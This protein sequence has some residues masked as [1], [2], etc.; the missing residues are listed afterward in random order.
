[1]TNVTRR[2]VLTTAA[3]GAAW[4]LASP[5]AQAEDVSGH[6]GYPFQLGVASGEPTHDGFVIWTRLA[7]DPLASDGLGGLGDKTTPVQW[8]VATDKKFAK[9]VAQGTAT[10]NHNVGHSVHVEVAKLPPNQ[11][12]Y[13]RF[14]ALGAES[15]VG[16]ARTAPAAGSFDSARIAVA[17]CAQWEHGWFS[18]YRDIA[19]KNPDLV[20]HLGDYIYEHGPLMYPV[21]SGRV[22]S[23]VGGETFSLA[24]YRRR[25]ALYRTDR[26][27]QQAHQ[28]APWVTVFDDHEVD[29]DWAGDHHEFWG[30]TQAFIRRKAAAFQAFYENMPLRVSQKPRGPHL[31]LHRRILW[32]GLFSLNM[33]DTRQYRDVQVCRWTGPCD[34]AREPQRAMLGSAQERWLKRGYKAHPTTWQIFGNQVMFSPYDE[35]PLSGVRHN[36]DGWDGYVA[37]RH[38]V[39]SDWKE[40][41]VANPV[42]LT[43]D[44]H[45]AFAFDVPEI[46][47]RGRIDHN[48]SPLGV[49][50]VTTSISSGGLGN[51]SV[52]ENDSQNPHLKLHQ[53]QRGYALV[54]VSQSAMEV[55]YR[56]IRKVNDPQSLVGDTAMR[57]VVAGSR[58]FS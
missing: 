31:E 7:I 44:Y 48:K 17:S 1:M 9:V 30:K 23:M 40:M 3:A 58:R 6:S 16:R 53:K 33:L 46:D 21:L 41:N 29:N 57:R 52:R 24:D 19:A 39:I 26:D 18:G 49:E 22:R 54:D 25:Y 42:V 55:T 8:Q 28:A 20:V 43:G 38:R 13:Y 15:A 36:M 32:G 2:T 12:F 4:A 5:T 34:A 10:T 11:W 45:H 27:L 37:A 50:V 51:D 35:N 47:A 14:Q 56:S